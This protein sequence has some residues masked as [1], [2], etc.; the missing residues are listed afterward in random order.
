[1]SNRV[2]TQRPHKLTR[3][4][5]LLL[6][7]VAAVIAGG[8]N[9]DGCTDNRS[10]LPLMGLY[11]ASTEQ[12]MTLDSI[13]IGGVDAPADS[14]LVYPGESVSSAYLPFRFDRTQTSFFF[15]Y[16]YKEQGL[17]NPEFNDTITFH[18]TSEPYF[19]SE[20]CGAFFIYH[21]GQVDY[22]THLIEE[23][24]ITDSLITNVEMERIKVFFRTADTNKVSIESS[25]IPS[26]GGRE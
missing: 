6:P 9:T 22:T 25:H 15:H 5:A 8:C 14:M 11:S 24:E 16:S 17:D 2:R 4:P 20:E 21:I 13:G 10:A 1:M 3:L 12:T 23:V 7:A 18:Y 26:G 19:A